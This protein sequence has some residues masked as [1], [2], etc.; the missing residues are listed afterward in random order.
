MRNAERC[1][2]CD[3]PLRYCECANKSVLSKKEEINLQVAT[4]HLYLLSERQIRHLIEI[5][6]IWDIWYS[7]ERQEILERRINND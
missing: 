1:P 2:I 3:Y 5:E 7:D 4:D 6:R